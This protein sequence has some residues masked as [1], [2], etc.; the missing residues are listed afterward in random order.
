MKE[1]FCTYEIAMKL[2]E[3][4]FNKGCLDIYYDNGDEDSESNWKLLLEKPKKS[5]KN[6]KEFEIAAPLWQQ[7][8]DFLRDEYNL[9]INVF[10]ISSNR[11]F[12][13]IRKFKI[14]PDFNFEDIV[15][16]PYPPGFAKETYEEAQKLA[17]LNAIELC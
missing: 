8:I 9:S 6:D 16:S 11:W 4:G 3:L 14:E 2:K 15:K 17:I 5:F 12:Y 13:S 1:L 7:A 10:P